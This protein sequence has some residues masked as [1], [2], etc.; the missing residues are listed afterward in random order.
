MFHRYKE[1][2]LLSL[3]FLHYR[4]RARLLIYFAFHKYKTQVYKGVITDFI[5]K[6][7]LRMPGIVGPI[8]G[9]V[10]GVDGG[11]T[12]EIMTGMH[13]TETLNIIENNKVI[14]K[15]EKNFNLD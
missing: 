3:M 13:D 5:R 1:K 11:G 9:A 7:E 6:Q 4:R 15:Y 8:S 2:S 12:Y 10:G 14:E